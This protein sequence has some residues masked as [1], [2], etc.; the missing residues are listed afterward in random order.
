[1]D[2]EPAQ[3]VQK[4]DAGQFRAFIGN[5]W[6][7]VER[8]QKNESGEFRVM[9]AA[10]AAAQQPSEIPV[11]RT[12][13]LRDTG[14]FL[15][16]VAAGGL[17]GAGSIGATFFRLFESAE[18]NA[19]RRQQMDEA[20]RS[21]GAEP[22]SLTYRGGKLAG[23]IAGTAGLGGALAKPVQMLAGS[24]PA[25]APIA[26]ALQSSGFTT[27]LVNR[28]VASAA[29]RAGAGAVTGGAGSALVNPEDA[30]GGA[31]GGAVMG[32]AAPVVIPAAAKAAGWVWD[33][34][35]GKLV[36]MK[37]GKV[38]REIA[39]T[40]LDAINKALGTAKPGRTAAQAVQEAGVINPVFQAMGEKGK[41]IPE[42]VSAMAQREL[43]EETARKAAVEGVTPDLKKALTARNLMSE[44]LYEAA[45]KQVVTLDQPF[46]ELFDRMPKGTVE[47]AANIA[48]MEGRPFQIGSYVPAHTVQTGVLDAAGNPIMQ[49]VPEQLPKITGDSLHYLKRALS[50]IS[51]ASPA[52]G[53]GKDAQQA[54]R[55]VLKEFMQQFEG[56]IS[57]YGAARETFAAMSEPVNQ[58]QVLNEMLSVLQKPGGGERVTP[59]LNALGR[60]E[61]SMLKRSTGVPRY[62]DISQVLTPPQMR[63]VKDVAG[64]LERDAQ[65]TRL[66]AEGK[67]ALAK[68]LKEDT[69]PITSPSWFNWMTTALNKVSSNLQGRVNDKTIKSI[70]Q[71]MESGKG[72]Q[73]LLNSVP[74]SE[75]NIVLKAMIDSQSWD[76]AVLSTIGAT[77]RNA[78]AP[79]RQRNQN[80][81][82][83]Q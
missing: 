13:F 41:A 76:P 80:A 49:Q 78:L 64:Q 46:L 73:D 2:W 59:F 42:L 51:N 79:N 19:I 23:E 24:I 11:G 50:D 61:Q 44:P 22:E 30:A 18:E 27:G 38:L 58:A 31:I 66:A 36:Q 14:Q 39:G 69:A 9:R 60:G 82:A 40:E 43:G 81:L 53:V 55:G 17:R 74:A 16:N 57:K 63:V 35:S 8:A 20:L 68:L 1:M 75:R 10:P 67:P 52:T 5:E 70:A 29:L 62:E 15:G 72:A 65:M 6:V 56:K 83:G 28:P 54:A 33:T 34:M 7:P 21:M 25:A 71:A 12:S 77:T 37:A 4:N 3:R 26:T 32:A 45:K 48:R 47:A